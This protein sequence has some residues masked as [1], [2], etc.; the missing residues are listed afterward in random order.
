MGE[1]YWAWFE[2]NSDNIARLHGE[3]QLNKIADVVIDVKPDSGVGHG[4]SVGIDKW[5]DN[6]FD[7]E[8]WN[9]EADL[10]P[11]ARSMLKLAELAIQHNRLSSAENAGIN[12]LR[13]KVAENVR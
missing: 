3:E 4:W 12:Y 5:V 13:N 7:R 2:R 1:V 8:P 9:I 10:L 11:D 6:R